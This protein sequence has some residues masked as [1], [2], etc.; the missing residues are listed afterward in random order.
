M[1]DRFDFAQKQKN[2]A[3]ILRTLDSPA[4][5]RKNQESDIVNRLR[6]IYENG[7]RHS[8]SEVFQVVSE[9]LRYNN[10]S[11]EIPMLTNLE[12]LL[13]T[14]R[15]GLNSKSKKAE[16]DFYLSIFK[17]RD[18]VNLEMARFQYLS[19]GPVSE[20]EGLRKKSLQIEKRLEQVWQES[21]NSAQ[22]I[23]GE[24]I[25]ILAIFAA[26]VIAFSGGFNLVT[27]A[28]AAMKSNEIGHVVLVVTISALALANSLFLM[29]Y[30][31]GKII[32]KSLKGLYIV[33]LNLF[34]ILLP[35][36]YLGYKVA[37]QKLACMN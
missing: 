37:Y 14:V 22:K 16:K 8:Y 33:M 17:L 13:D 2:L 12:Y 5:D 10:G 26:V 1:F 21:Q 7:F 31:V 34:L 23:H 30:Y 11:E 18:H 35:L 24:S 29:M 28:I 9:S 25:S 6:A 27:S 32:N 4:Y 3:E 20:I 19:D 36:L 15:Q